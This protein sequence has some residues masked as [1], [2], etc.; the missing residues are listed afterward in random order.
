MKHS[1]LLTVFLNSCFLAFSQ[2]NPK[3]VCRYG[4]TFEIST[5]K[6][7]GYHKPV[8][9]SVTPNSSA[10][11]AGLYANDIIEKINEKNTAGE[12]IETIIDWLQNSDNQIQLAVT[13]L[14]EN[15]EP[16]TLDKYCLLNNSLTERDLAS[17][18][19]FYSLENVQTRTFICPFKTSA[20][21][22][23]DLSKY[24]SFGFENKNVTDIQSETRIKEAIKNCLIQKGLK[25]LEKNPDLTVKIQYSN[26]VNPNFRKSLQSDKLPLA[27]RY[28]VNTKSMEKLPIFD[29][30]LINT[31]QAEFFLKLAIRL[32]D[33][34]ANSNLPVWE[35]EAGE[36]LQSAYL[37]ADYAELHLPL[38]FM[39]YPYIKSTEAA[40]FY[41]S[42]SKYNFT[43]I[44]YNMNKL[45]E[46]TEVAPFSPAE[47][48][49]IKAGDI[50]EKING[51]KF[52]NKIKT[53]DNKYKQFIFK[54]FSLRDPATQFSNAE[55]FSRCMYWDKEK[56]NLILDEFRKPDFS[57]AFSYLF[58][59][60]PYINLSGGMNIVSFNI[61]SGKNKEEIKINPVIYSEEIFEN[62]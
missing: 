40:Q 37:V 34:K 12:N 45:K 21:A 32:F 61:K 38:M 24:S 48:A 51:I 41:Y 9:L 4:F 27:V 15:Q 33:A 54:T 11:A 19:S 58:Y 52:E 2:T 16:R 14:K 3:I 8:I 55:G 25:F 18:Y 60:E 42:C 49:G 47:K 22:E 44:H 28:N 26:E 35:C 1:I 6:N 50:V 23:I 57:T 46:I 36:L 13:N 17:I 53:A 30:P 7:W 29:N 5:Q 10:D 62:R 56:Y 20:K 31:N 39:Q 43:G 59:F